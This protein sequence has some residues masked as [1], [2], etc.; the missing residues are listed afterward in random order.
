MLERRE[1]LQGCQDSTY[2]TQRVYVH[3][4]PVGVT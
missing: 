4:K 2:G 3:Q 1:T